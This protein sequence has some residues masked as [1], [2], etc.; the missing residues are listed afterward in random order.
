MS[1][2]YPSQTVP[3]PT[4]KVSIIIPAFNA[5]NFLPETLDSVL[6]QTLKAD[7]IFLVDDGSTDGTPDIAR[8]YRAHVQYLHQEN[9]GVAAARNRGLARATGEFVC[10]LDADDW[11]YPDNLRLKVHFLARNPEVGLVHG[12]VDVTDAEL[13][14]TGEILTGATGEIITDLLRFSPPAIPCPS[15]ALMR[16]DLVEDVGGFDESLGTSADFDLWLKIAQRTI[17]GRVDEVV[18]KYRRHE[19]AMFHNLG[20][21]LRDMGHI[22]E[23]HEAELG[24][25]HEWRMLQWRFYRSV[26]GAYRL[27]GKPWRAIP[28]LISGVRS[29][30]WLNR[31][32]EKGP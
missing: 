19:G 10:F 5:A 2:G 30:G 29:G 6:N 12:L 31:E 14:S 27:Q 32:C 17:V 18:I 13:E 20:A 9:Q 1:L 26:A 23:K 22:F 3:R 15:N 4:P 16:R 21:Q 7:E 28:P 8:S 24:N 25:T 11:F